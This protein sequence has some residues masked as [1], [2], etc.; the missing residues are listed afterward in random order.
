MRTERKDKQRPRLEDELEM[1]IVVEAD[2]LLGQHGGG[3]WKHDKANLNLVGNFLKTLPERSRAVESEDRFSVSLGRSDESS[4]MEEY[5]SPDGLEPREVPKPVPGDSEVL[6]RI[7]AT[8]V[9][10][11]DCEMQ[12]LEFPVLLGLLMRTYSGLWKSRCISTLTE[13]GRCP[14]ANPAPLRSIRG[15]WTSLTSNKKVI[16]GTAPYRTE[17]LVLLKELVEAG[18][19]QSSID[20]RYPLEQI[21]EA[22][23]YVETGQNKGNVV[24]TVHHHGAI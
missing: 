10:A 3:P 12:R 17:D 16:S 19:L 1:V 13:G 14:L 8:T 9:T 4:G 6:V 11:G 15:G 18:K 5:G 23:R 21:A 2:P 22:H 20:R 7:H 24:V